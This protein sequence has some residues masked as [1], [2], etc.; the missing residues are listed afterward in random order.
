MR[1]LRLRWA[2]ATR[3]EIVVWPAVL[4]GVAVALTSF[5]VG[6]KRGDIRVDIALASMAAFLFGA[7]LAFTIVRT[8][9]RLALV[10]GLVARG[11]SALFSIH[12]MVVVF[13]R[14]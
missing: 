8:R 12:Q 11:N 13:G 14:H 6:P 3:G 9:E 7:L 5:L 1:A 4:A 2:S 10:H